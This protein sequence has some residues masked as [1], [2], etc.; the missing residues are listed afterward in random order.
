[1]M[2]RCKGSV[3]GWLL[4]ATLR[5]AAQ[6][7]GMELSG[8][9]VPEYTREGVMK[10]QLF[11]EHAHVLPEGQ[12]KLRGVTVEFYDG[13]NVT[14]RVISPGCF[15]NRADHSARSDEPVRIE[16]EKLTVTGWDYELCGKASR[17][18]IRREVRVVLKDVKTGFKPGEEP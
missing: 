8:F 5:V 14:A 11:G 2:R 17:L 9:R 6:E 4:I 16:L 18:V 12:I 10:S 7:A 15:F 1:M 13:T 3:A